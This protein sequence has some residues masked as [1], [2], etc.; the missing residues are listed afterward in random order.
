M[1]ADDP[2]AAS[3]AVHVGKHAEDQCR[4]FLKRPFNGLDRHADRV[5]GLTGLGT[6]VRA[7]GTD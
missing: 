4:I 3:L 7:G 1:E 6:R 2:G 5:F